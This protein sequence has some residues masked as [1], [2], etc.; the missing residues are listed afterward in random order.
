MIEAAKIWN[1]PNIKMFWTHPNSQAYAD[2]LERSAIAI[3]YVDPDATIV[4]GG[5]GMFLIVIGSMTI[6]NRLVHHRPADEDQGG[7][8]VMTGGVL[9]AGVYLFPA[10]IALASAVARERRRNTLESLLSLPL[11]RRF[12][13]STKVRTAIERGWWC[14]PLSIAC[15]RC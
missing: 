3:R 1:E 9:L 10:G 15:G 13:L 11:D 2:M 4:F 7:R 14:A 6:T 5:L 8:L 12:V